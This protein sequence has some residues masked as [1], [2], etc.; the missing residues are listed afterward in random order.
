MKN[1]KNDNIGNCEDGKI[2]PY[3]NCGN[4]KD[5][6]ISPKKLQICNCEDGKISPNDNIGNSE[7]GKIS[8]MI[9]LATA[10][11]ANFQNGNIGNS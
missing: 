10:R 9:T 7:D 8:K 6:K 1:F 4:Y 11:M 2:S 3:D 5:G